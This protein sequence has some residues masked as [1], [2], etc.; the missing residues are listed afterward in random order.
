MSEL[1]VIAYRRSGGEARLAD[2]LEKGLVDVAVT[3]AAVS[4]SS[5]MAARSASHSSN[6][7]RG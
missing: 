7:K 5:R 2:A 4:V 6:G 3:R 1:I